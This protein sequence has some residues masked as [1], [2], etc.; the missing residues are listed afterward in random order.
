MFFQDRFHLYIQHNKSLPGIILEGNLKT[1]QRNRLDINQQ[2]VPPGMDL[3]SRDMRLK[4]ESVFLLLNPYSI[5]MQQQAAGVFMKNQFIQKR[6]QQQVQLF[7]FQA[8]GELL[9]S[10]DMLG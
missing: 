6:Q 10:F 2:M 1:M 7:I 5:G 4:S 8:D 9:S 3:F